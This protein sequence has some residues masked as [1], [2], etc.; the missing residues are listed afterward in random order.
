MINSI[1]KICTK[2]RII[3]SRIDNE[4][5]RKT[6]YSLNGDIRKEKTINVREMHQ[7]RR[8]HR[9]VKDFFEDMICNH[10]YHES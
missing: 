9:N 5:V 7:N 2:E 10:D 1:E 8:N 4:C 3:Y 6:N